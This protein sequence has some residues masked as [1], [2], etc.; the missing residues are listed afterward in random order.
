MNLTT[1][2]IVPKLKRTRT[3]DVLNA[4]KQDTKAEKNVKEKAIID[5]A[6]ESLMKEVSLVRAAERRLAWHE[7]YKAALSTNHVPF[8]LS[9]LEK[10]R[11]PLL[12]RRRLITILK[13]DK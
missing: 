4:P 3:K 12:S 1:K 11:T 9:V 10:V 5:T 7:G 6:L 13:L 2:R 8:A